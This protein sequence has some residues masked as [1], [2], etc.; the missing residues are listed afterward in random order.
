MIT[1]IERPVPPAGLMQTCVMP[2]LRESNTVGD[3]VQNQ[4]ATRQALRDCAARME[5]LIG[6]LIAAS[7]VAEEEQE[8]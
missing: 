5:A 7:D 4:L 2:V 3:V 1:Q 8:Q 6:W